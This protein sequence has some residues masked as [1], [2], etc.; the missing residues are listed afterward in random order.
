VK[1]WLFNVVKMDRAGKETLQ[2]KR[3]GM[4]KGTWLSGQGA[5]LENVLLKRR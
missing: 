3:D 5:M 2:N 1:F 4:E